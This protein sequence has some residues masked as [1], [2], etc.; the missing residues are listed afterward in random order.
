MFYGDMVY[1]FMRYKLYLN[2]PLTGNFLYFLDFQKTSFCIIISLFPKKQ[3]GQKK[4][5]HKD[6]DFGYCL[7]D[8]LSP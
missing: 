7:L 3:L 5:P 6:K 1:F 4:C 8:I 2:L